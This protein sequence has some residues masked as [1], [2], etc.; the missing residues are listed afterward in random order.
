MRHAFVWKDTLI[1]K[2]FANQLPYCLFDWI[3]FDY[4]FDKVL[5]CIEWFVKGL[6]FLSDVL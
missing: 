5:F 3:N 1:D 4:I 2:E 6:C